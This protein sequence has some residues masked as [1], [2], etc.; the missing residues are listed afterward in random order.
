MYEALSGVKKA[1]LNNQIK[2]D[3]SANDIEKRKSSIDSGTS[4]K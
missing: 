3:A 4:G 1:H 2:N